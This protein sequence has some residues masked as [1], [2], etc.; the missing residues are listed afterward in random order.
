MSVNAANPPLAMQHQPQEATSLLMRPVSTED[1]MAGV[2][3]PR[4]FCLRLVTGE[5]DKGDEQNQKMIFMLIEEHY[6]GW[7]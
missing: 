1:A 3:P 4:G 2:L 5:R 6:V 7:W